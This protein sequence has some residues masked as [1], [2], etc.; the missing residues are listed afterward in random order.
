MDIEVKS[1]MDIES[2][3]QEANKRINKKYPLLDEPIKEWMTE[4][5]LEIIKEKDGHRTRNSLVR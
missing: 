2:I 1:K 3:T 5:I 4:I